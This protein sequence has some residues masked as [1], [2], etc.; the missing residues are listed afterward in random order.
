M[1]K[2]KLR[3]PKWVIIVVC[4]LIVSVLIVAIYFVPE[5]IKNKT[6]NNGIC[7]DY[8]CTDVYVTSQGEDVY[9]DKA[10]SVLTLSYVGTNITVYS[11]GQMDDFYENYTP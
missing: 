8:T 1:Q 11:D 2:A 3:I 5:Y 4:V 6:F 10:E 9:G 7:G